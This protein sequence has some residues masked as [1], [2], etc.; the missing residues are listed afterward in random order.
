M[1]Y[2][3]NYQFDLIGPEKSY[4]FLFGW[5]NH[6]T[7]LK[8]DKIKKN[9]TYIDSNKLYIEYDFDTE[10]KLFMFIYLTF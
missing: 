5:K 7:V 3:P 8:I 4:C 10:H 2:F 6:G 1:G 9:T